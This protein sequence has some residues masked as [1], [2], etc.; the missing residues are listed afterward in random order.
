MQNKLYHR[1]HNI[2]R[3][4]HTIILYHT[5]QKSRYI[6][7]S[8]FNCIVLPFL[9]HRSNTRCTTTTTGSTCKMLT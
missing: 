9:S 1:L 8:K 2:K 5:F 3:F 7:N 6:I 4:T